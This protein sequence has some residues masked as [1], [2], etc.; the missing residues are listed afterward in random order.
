MDH[1]HID[2]RCNSS[3]QY[4]HTHVQLGQPC[5]PIKNAIDQRR[6]K[7]VVETPTC[8][9]RDKQYTVVSRCYLRRGQLLKDEEC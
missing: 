7:V 2:H 3:K 6:Q 8:L 5:E 9:Q 4:Q 1:H